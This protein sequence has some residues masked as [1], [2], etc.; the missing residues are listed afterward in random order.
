[1]I[2]SAIMVMLVTVLAAAIFVGLQVTNSP[3]THGAKSTSSELE[4]SHDVQIATAWFPSDVRSASTI[5][6]SPSVP[7]CVAPMDMTEATDLIDFSEPQIWGSSQFG[8]E[9]YYVSYWY[10]KVGNSYELARATGGPGASCSS[11]TYVTIARDLSSVAAPTIGCGTPASAANCSSSSITSVKLTLYEGDGDAYAIYGEPNKTV[12]TSVSGAGTLTDKLYI[13]GNGSDVLSASGGTSLTVGGNVAIDSGAT[14]AVS[15]SGFASISAPGSLI[16][17][18]PGGTCSA[19]SSG[20]CATNVTP[21][22]NAPAPLSST[23]LDPFDNATYF[24]PQPDASLYTVYTFTSCPGNICPP[25]L[26]TNPVVLTSGTNILDTGNYDFEQGLFVNDTASLS[27]ASGGVFIYVGCP[28]A[29]PSDAPACTNDTS[30]VVGFEGTGTVTLSPLSDGSQYAGMTIFQ[31]RDDTSAFVADTA[32]GGLSQS[33]N[34]IVYVPAAPVILG[35][36]DSWSMGHLIC[37]SLI[38]GQ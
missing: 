18:L 22:V 36:Y 11:E 15:V 7:V 26:Y 16:Q 28:S 6:V 19:T 25:G 34:G 31:A 1:M 33:I 10:G 14:G 27:S 21:N 3:N 29:A 20:S 30:A 24:L 9:W 32:G 17:T 12:A 23:S 4:S 5:V 8:N 2:A 38:L 37:N 35:G 13:I